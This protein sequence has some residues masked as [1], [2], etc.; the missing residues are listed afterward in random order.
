MTAALENAR[1]SKDCMKQ[2][3][4]NNGFKYAERAI[5]RIEELYELRKEI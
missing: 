1:L 2:N 4:L 3:N 5:K